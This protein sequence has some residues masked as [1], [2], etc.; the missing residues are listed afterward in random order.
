MLTSKKS[1]LLL[2]FSE[3][4]KQT[5]A[6]TRELVI[7]LGRENELLGHPEPN[8]LQRVNE[9]KIRLLSTLEGLD[10]QRGEIL[11]GLGYRNND[12]GMTQCLAEAPAA[13][14][15]AGIWQDTRSELQA[16][17]RMNQINGGAI[18]LSRRHAQQALTLLRGGLMDDL[19]NQ[20]GNNYNKPDGRS[21]AK[22]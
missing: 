17:Q 9:E 8:N 1:A 6:C 21:L 14:G 11:A 19:Y 12:D 5:L 18:E 15:L 7:C 16:C 13:F 20:K 4:L 22:A 3:T 10:Q 2:T